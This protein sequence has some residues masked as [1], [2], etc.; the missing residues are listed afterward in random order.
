MNN[1]SDAPSHS[2]L[3][4]N[5]EHSPFN[6][7][8]DEDFTNQGWP[9]Q[10]TKENP[11]L[12]QGFTITTNGVCLGVF[13]TTRHFIVENC[14]FLSGPEGS[15][16]GV[17]ILFSN[18]SNGVVKFSIFQDMNIG[19]LLLNIS[20]CRITNNLLE[21]CT[22]SEIF[23]EFIQN[24]SLANNRVTSQRSWNGIFVRRSLDCNV[25]NNTVIGYSERSTFGIGVVATNKSIINFN[26]VM[27]FNYGIQ[28][29]GYSLQLAINDLWGCNTG[30]SIFDS[31][32]CLVKT[33]WIK[34][35]YYGVDI[36]D[37]MNCTLI[38]SVISENQYG[39][40]LGGVQNCSIIENHIIDNWWGLVFKHGHRSN[41][42][43]C[44]IIDNDF[45][46][47]G[48]AFEVD[49]ASDWHQE[50]H[51]NTVNEKPF[52]YF[53]SISNAKLD[54][55]EYGQIILVDCK[56]IT[57]SGGEFYNSSIGI[58]LAFCVGCAVSTININSNIYGVLIRDSL[59]C[60]LI[61]CDIH[62]LG[63]EGMSVYS[64][65]GVLMSYSHN[66]SLSYSK[67]ELNTIGICSISTRYYTI[68]SNTISNN[69]YGIDMIDSNHSHI[70]NNII[71]YNVETGISISYSS[72]Q[73]S[74]YGND[75]GWNGQNAVDN[76]QNNTWD[77]GINR[78]NK[79]SDY[80]GSEVYQ[81]PGAADAKDNYPLLLT[82]EIGSN[83]ILI[84]L[85][86]PIGVATW[87]FVNLLAKRKLSSA[88]D[89]DSIKI[90]FR[91]VLLSK[92]KKRK[93]TIE[94]EDETDAE[95]P[96]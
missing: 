86:L 89:H 71:L 75:I 63:H 6:I 19:L 16:K 3:L 59:E 49:V 92:L 1:I 46:N 32:N 11:Y 84:W 91:Y 47:N 43:G 37:S 90:P 27:N 80:D 52:G 60:K 93:Q 76:G 13:N 53:H 79:W 14:S 25:F 58:T 56:N 23:A 7:T 12:I 22:S 81:I 85:I 15:L 9:G 21:N 65:A 57:V 29:S 67:I 50:F 66:C 54:G 69:T 82:K 88:N 95:T 34:D 33:N 2:F 8:C 70:I 45:Q 24:C 4:T 61:S 55:N 44:R 42:S 68:S 77:N 78:G 20:K 18:V 87:V 26:T 41:S 96:S 30:V 5:S 64:E 73:N 28:I 48:I 51:G 94:P 17:G 40:V 74:I 35:G 31:I 39:V 38:W 83:L 72:M 62:G 36:H 10:G